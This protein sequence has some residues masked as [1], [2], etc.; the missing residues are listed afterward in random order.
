MTEPIKREDAVRL[1]LSLIHVLAIEKEVFE[2]LDK[3]LN[4]YEF[5]HGKRSVKQITK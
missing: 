5:E 3:K 1:M 2:K 4:P